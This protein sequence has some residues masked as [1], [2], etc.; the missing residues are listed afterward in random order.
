MFLANMRYARVLLFFP[1]DTTTTWESPDLDEGDYRINIVA[2]DLV[3]NVGSFSH[4]FTIDKTAP[5]VTS[6]R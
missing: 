6:M 3:G 1:A 4:D 2:S 5:N